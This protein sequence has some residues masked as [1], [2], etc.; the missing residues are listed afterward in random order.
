MMYR[1]PLLLSLWL[2]GAAGAL[3]AGATVPGVTKPFQVRR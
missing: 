2:A 3:A 1:I